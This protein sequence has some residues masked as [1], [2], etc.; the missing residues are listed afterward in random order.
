MAGPLAEHSAMPTLRTG[1]RPAIRPPRVR[2]LMVAVALVAVLIAGWKWLAWSGDVYRK[3]EYCRGCGSRN[4]AEAKEYW[5]KA[6]DP[7]LSKE[8]AQE[9]R[10]VAR[11]RAIMARKFLAVAADPTLP[12]PGTPYPKNP[13]FTPEEVAKEPDQPADP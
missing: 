2:T 12:Y 5:R 7:N 4:A 6:A 3:V 11:S 8:E 9:H 1:R 10:M 13:M